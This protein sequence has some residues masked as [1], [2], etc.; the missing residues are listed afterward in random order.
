MLEMV[1]EEPS[2]RAVGQGLVGLGLLTEGLDD[3]IDAAVPLGGFTL[4]AGEWGQRGGAAVW[5][6]ARISARM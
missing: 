1:G 5:A 2:D 6:R 3:G 4:N